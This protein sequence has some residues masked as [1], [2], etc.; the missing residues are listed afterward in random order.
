MPYESEAGAM[1]SFVRTPGAE[2]R[3]VALLA[4]AFALTSACA[5]DASAQS[6][7]VRPVRVIVPLAPGG[8]N[9]TLARFMAK[10]LSEA[11]GQQHRGQRP[12]AVRAT[13]VQ[14]QGGPERLLGRLQ[15]SRDLVG[16]AQVVMMLRRRRVRHPRRLGIPVAKFNLRTR[17]LARPCVPRETPRRGEAS[18]R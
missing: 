5:A 8:G 9:D 12:A 11:L 7:P 10:P 18:D 13:G 1:L 16:A 14:G 15:P 6:Y 4:A 2:M 3:P 17:P